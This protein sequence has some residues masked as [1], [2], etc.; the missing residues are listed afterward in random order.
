MLTKETSIDI[1]IMGTSLSVR[2]ATYI[3]E[4]GVRIAG[5]TYHRSG[6]DPGADLTREEPIVQAAAAIAWQDDTREVVAKML[7]DEK[8]RTAVVRAALDR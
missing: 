8:T 1:T 3:L 6:Y 5:P 2:R 7:K 4:D